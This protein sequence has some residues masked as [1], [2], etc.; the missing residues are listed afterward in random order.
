MA[1]NL[2]TS[3]EMA[4]LVSKQLRERRLGLNMS[5]KTLSERSGVSH[6]TL[7]NFERTGQI[8]LISL[9]KLS[10]VLEALDDFKIL[11]AKN[12]KENFSSLEEVLKD[13]SRKRGRE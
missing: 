13:T 10:V 7:R 1:F 11:F 6:S 4:R 2:M 5:Q 3:E 9:L 12:N 8:S